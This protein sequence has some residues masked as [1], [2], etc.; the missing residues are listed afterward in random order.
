MRT[1]DLYLS[2]FSHK[3]K[4]NYLSKNL[5]ALLSFGGVPREYFLGLLTN[6]L[7]DAQSVFS[8]KRAALRGTFLNQSLLLLQFLSMLMLLCFWA[9]FLGQVLFVL[10]LISRS[11]SRTSF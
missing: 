11:K 6:A 4:K 10:I 3:P 5:I 2:S 1:P 9:P 7:E 8:N